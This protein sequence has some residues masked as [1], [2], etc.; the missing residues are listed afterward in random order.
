MKWL[1]DFLG[2]AHAGVQRVAAQAASVVQ[3]VQNAVQ[4]SAQ[5]G[6]QGETPWQAW[7]NA[8]IISPEE[9]VELAQW[10]KATSSN[11]GQSVH[12]G[13]T[14]TADG[15]E[16]LAAIL[17]Q[18]LVEQGVGSRETDGPVAPKE[19]RMGAM[20]HYFRATLAKMTAAMKPDAHAKPTDDQKSAM[21]R[22]QTAFVRLCRAKAW[23]I[24]Q[25]AVGTPVASEAVLPVAEAEAQ[26]MAAYAAH[27]AACE[28][29]YLP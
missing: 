1:T 12:R 11:V 7:I 15:M 21:A 5:S 16:H 3:H 8:R 17:K 27:R 6:P 14:Q 23:S 4:E 18:A 20:V 19:D 29:R 28:Q 22:M 2:K 25:S 26:F 13:A 10:L 9:Q 24:P